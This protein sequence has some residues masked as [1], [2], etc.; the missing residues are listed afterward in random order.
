MTASLLTIG[1][2]SRVTHLS[3]KALRFYH[4]EGLLEPE[5]VDPSNG[6]REYG[7]DQIR[8]AQVIRRLR[9][10]DMPVD[11]VREVL[12]APDVESRN[13]LIGRHLER[14]EAQLDE[15]RAAVSSLRDLLTRPVSAST[16]EYRT[17]AEQHVLLIDATLDLT[18]LGAFFVS[19]MHE[20]DETVTG[21]GAV[22][23]GPRGGLWS[24]ALFLEERGDGAVFRPVDP[25]TVGPLRAGRV[26]Q[27]VLPPVELA[28]SVHSGPDSEIDR[29]YGAL[30][31]HVT[32]HELS[33]EGPIRESYLVSA[34]DTDLG[35]PVTEIGWPIFRTF[36]SAADVDGELTFP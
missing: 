16:I 35:G 22:S 2:F 4:R 21:S 32:R 24:T 17:I 8:T 9:D 31:E 23:V 34:F 33:V 5:S 15:T 3:A 20:L 26:R 1:D 28:V 18:E 25:A 12:R 6:Y 19:A 11:A 27:T 13:G 10:L 14:M 36:G 30:G 7:L 29:T